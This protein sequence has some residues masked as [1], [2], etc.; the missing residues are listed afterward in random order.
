M[1]ATC[2][3]YVKYDKSRLQGVIAQAETMTQTAY[4]NATQAQWDNFMAAYQ[5]ATS[6]YQ[7]G[8][9][10]EGEIS[11]TTNNLS[12]AITVLENTNGT[13]TITNIATLATATSTY[14]SSW[15]SVAAV[16]D[17]NAT[18]GNKSNV[19]PDGNQT[20][21]YGNWGSG[22]SQS[23][24]LTWSSAKT[25]TSSSILFYDN[26]EGDAVYTGQGLDVWEGVGTPLPM[27]I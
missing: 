25:V 6:C 11:T 17:G 7:N 27:S 15:N 4:P 18:A 8:A 23:V 21:V 19:T 20:S 13:V 14:T 22:A 3:V 5:A 9:A 2:N 26:R 16:N 10:T 1:A 24:T 12:N